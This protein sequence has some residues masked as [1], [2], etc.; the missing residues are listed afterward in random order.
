MNCL[1]NYRSHE[2]H[3][4]CSQIFP[5]PN[6]SSFPFFARN[7]SIPFSIETH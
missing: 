4:H 7:C 1:T 3:F 5:F 2:F 6:F